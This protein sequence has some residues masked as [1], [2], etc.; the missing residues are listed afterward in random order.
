MIPYAQARLVA[1]H[2]D[3]VGTEIVS[4]ERAL[5]RIAAQD[6]RSDDDIVPFA[7]AAMDG[8][9]I[10][11]AD[12]LGADAGGVRLPVAATTYAG[13]DKLH[14]RPRTA[15]AIATGA[16]LPL[17]ADA[18][19]AI[20]DTHAAGEAVVIPSGVPAGCHVFPPGED[21]RRGDHLVGRAERLGPG[22]VALLAAAGKS[23]IS[24]FRRPRVALVCTGDELVA[25]H[26]RPRLGQIRNSNA[27]LIA[28]S[29]WALGADVVSV[30]RCC[31]D[32]KAL[33]SA[34]AAALGEADLLLTTGGASNG[35]RDFVKDTL[36]ALGAQFAFDS[37]ALRPGKPTAIGRIRRAWVGVLPGNPAAAF[38][39]FTTLVRPLMAR[40]SGRIARDPETVSA[41]LR[42]PMHARAG[43]QHFVFAKLG[44]DRSGFWA[45]PLGNQCSALVATAARADCLIALEPDNRDLSGGEAVWVEVI[46]WQGVDFSAHR[47]QA[48]FAHA[49]IFGAAR[50]THA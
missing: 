12:T 8:F 22:A 29:V 34:M 30:Q 38:V 39:A 18:V 31:D 35:P 46:D 13:D 11:S 33:E 25:V 48:G 42:A 43:R 21:A 40:L 1:E 32:R 6:V 36:A 4:I 44:H 9:A 10:S 27:S 37:V 49:S 26:E 5:N 7:R 50:E 23:S 3:P 15:T 24:V 20:E 41:R 28:A 47:R 16:V 19:V 45:Q 14:H 2:A 17:G